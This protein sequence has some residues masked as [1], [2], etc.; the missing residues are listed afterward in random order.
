[1]ETI[2]GALTDI[3]LDSI[4]FRTR[5]EF[6]PLKGYQQILEGGSHMNVMEYDLSSFS[7]SDASARIRGVL[8]AELAR[9]LEFTHLPLLRCTAFQKPNQL[10]CI[11]V[12][13]HHSII[14]EQ[15]LKEFLADFSGKFRGLTLSP[16]SV[17]SRG[18]GRMQ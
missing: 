16:L 10:T 6:D 18:A 4:I 11:L 2:R 14:D 9:P 8:R 17:T 12:N 13:S 1:M 7:P 5:F 3:V 15:S